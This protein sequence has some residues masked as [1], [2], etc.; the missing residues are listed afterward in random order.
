[1]RNILKNKKLILLCR[2]L[3][4][5]IF[6]YASID[7][8]I[9]PIDFSNNIDNYHIT[10][11]SLNNIA[12]LV[13]PWL[14]V[15]LGFCLIFGVYLNTAATLVI[16]LLIWFI[17]ILTQALFRGINLHCGCFSNLADNVNDVNLQLEMYYR[18]IQDFVLLAMAFIVK[19]RNEL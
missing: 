8:I 14:E 10:P 17:F 2:I 4:G 19:F 9:N 7:K 6:I 13:I 5:I 16:M 3:L 18:I 11:V 1:M 12:A 15:I